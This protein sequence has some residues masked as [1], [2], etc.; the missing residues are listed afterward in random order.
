MYFIFS[1]SETARFEQLCK[2]A[3]NLDVKPLQLDSVVHQPQACL[4]LELK[5]SM[6]LLLDICEHLKQQ[7]F[8]GLVYV[9]SEALDKRQDTL[10]HKVLTSY[11]LDAYIVNGR[12]S[13]EQALEWVCQ[14][15][16]NSRSR[17]VPQESLYD[18]ELIHELVVAGKMTVHYQAQFQSDS[19]ELV[20]FEAL[21]RL[22]HE[23]KS[24]P[25]NE[26]FD[27]I[28]ERSLWSYLT[29]STLK[30]S[31][32]T[33]HLLFER[34]PHANLAINLSAKELSEESFSDQF[35]TFLNDSPIAHPRLMFEL[36]ETELY[37]TRSS[38][39]RNLLLI[40]GKGARLSIDDYGTGLSNAARLT[41]AP[42]DELKLDKSFIQNIHDISEHS[43]AK[44]T[45][46]I[47]R[48]LH[49]KTVAEGVEDQR[50]LDCVRELG[51]EQVQGFLLH[52]PQSFDDL[53]STDIRLT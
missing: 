11:G 25:L 37:S 8:E 2:K 49:M 1:D 12:E 16:T 41:T 38:V 44:S 24:V 47:A 35:K 32:E 28:H 4:V 33:H 6:T 15:S 20:A 40:K 13:T 18:K 31:L 26:V 23:G 39:S 50:T 10:M 46:E 21:A 7:D 27:V 51:I 48:T 29:Q 52:K 34:Y 5:S 9:L 45:A 43:F 22:Y 36:T 42:F 19:L 3:L 17:S 53:M 14:H 30:N